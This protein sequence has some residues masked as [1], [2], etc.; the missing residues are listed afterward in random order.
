VFLLSTTH[1]P[2]SAGLAAFRAVV[3]AYSTEDPIGR[4]E[5]AGRALS[6]AVNTAAAEAGLEDHIEVIGRP[7]CLIFVA[8]DA[9]RRPS[10]EFRTLLL[11]ELLARGV[12]G[13][14]FVVSAAHTDADIALTVDAVRAAL[15]VY[16]RALG[17][18]SATPFLR[19][20]PVA[21]ALRARAVPRRIMPE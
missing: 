20:R 3:R 11:Q 15:P 7:S 6:T 17:A 12:L 5:S 4:M 18:G 1:G 8:R 9:D 16:Q 19:G 2:E 21:P 14:S 13:Q 10:Q